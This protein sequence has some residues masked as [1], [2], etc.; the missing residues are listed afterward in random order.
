MKNRQGVKYAIAVLLLGA[1]VLFIHFFIAQKSQRPLARMT[2]ITQ[3]EMLLNEVESSSRLITFDNAKINLLSEQVKKVAQAYESSP[4]DVFEAQGELQGLTSEA[5]QIHLKYLQAEKQLA[6]APDSIQNEIKSGYDASIASSKQAILSNTEKMK[7]ALTVYKTELENETVTA[8]IYEIIFVFSLCILL[9][10]V[11]FLTYKKVEHVEN[12][13]RSV[14]EKSEKETAR[15]ETM[16]RVVEAIAEGRYAENI[17]FE[18]GDYLAER[19]V[20]M[21]NKL[22]QSAE[23]DRRR[24]WATQGLAEIGTILRDTS[25]F[26]K[27]CVN[28]TKYCVTYTKSNQASLFILNEEDPKNQYLELVST[29]TYGRRKFQNKKIAVGEGLVGQAVLE[30]Q[31]IFMKKLPQNYTHITSGLGEATP[32]ALVIVPLKLNDK[33]FGVLEMASFQ[34]YED[35]EIQFLE[36]LGESVAATISTARINEQTRVLLEKSQQQTEE[37]RAQEEEVRQNMEELSATQEHMA[38]QM[39][40]IKT[41]AET[42]QVREDVFALTTILSESDVFGTITL[43]NNK[44]VEV[45]K[46]SREELIGKPHNIF[47][48]PDMPSELFKLFWETIKQG[49]VFKGIIKNRAKDGTHYWV[50][51]TIVPVKDASGKIIK[52][53]GARYHITDDSFAEH[54]YNLQAAKLNLPPLTQTKRAA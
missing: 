46:Y 1:A 12:F 28:I 3:V 7:N 5:E 54:F 22:L 4:E 23:M 39:E 49:K 53:I 18:K 34:A 47:R 52:Y 13:T 11:A 48:H 10:I 16:K 42:L 14:E 27:L 15:I 38:R 37:L 51:A 36:T 24:N 31:T 50:D 44:L 43:A 30:A 41:M 45:S 9:G 26:E 40:E 25:N 29:Y 2:E 21:K 19:L 35:L 17:T 6:N 20:E 32:S 33:V 8:G